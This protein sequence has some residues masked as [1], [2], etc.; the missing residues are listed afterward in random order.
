MIGVLLCGMVHMA[1]DLSEEWMKSVREQMN[2]VNAYREVGTFRGAAVLCG[3]THKTVKRVVER[4]DRGEVGRRPAQPLKTAIVGDLIEKRLRL[5]DGRISAKRLL[6]VTQAAGYTGSLRTLQRAVKDA[7]ASW[8]LR[9]REYRPWLPTPGQYLVAD[10]TSEA[11]WEVFCAVL[12]WSHHR[13]VRFAKDQRRETTLRLVAE[14]FEELGGVAAVVLTDRM[15]CLKAG[16][17]ANVVVPHP[18]YVR[19]AAHYGFQPDFCEAADPESKGLVENLAGYVQ[20]DLIIPALMEGGWPDEASANVAAKVWCAEVNGRVHSEIA[21]IPAER[22]AVEQVV[23]RPLPSLRPPL[24]SGEPRKVD[25]LGMVRFGSG[26]YAV[27]QDLVGKV[28]EVRAED[29]AVI[30]SHQ[31]S[32][33]ASHLPVAP[34]EV[35][36][37]R[38]ALENR[39]PARGVR[40]RTPAEIAFLSLGPS[41]E[42]FLRAAAAAGTL[43]LESELAEI[44]T[45]EAAWGREALTRALERGLRFRRFKAHDI[46]AILA[47]ANGA[48]TPTAAGAQLGLALP[49]VPERPLDAYAFAALGA[50]R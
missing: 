21:A 32:E 33:I 37:G 2:I 16:I 4:Q 15:A 26:R 19:F 22:L 8:K 13:F 14:C 39:R 25:R 24:R 36:L 12:A 18:E 11:G 45:L 47:T 44:A 23:L 28:V 49:P 3:T 27:A 40:P 41:A 31:G 43:R 5:T 20:T 38:F 6:P 48:P 35:A 34:G 42:A 1:P 7:K 10:W 29:G 17:V 9:R 50:R 30:I 46:R